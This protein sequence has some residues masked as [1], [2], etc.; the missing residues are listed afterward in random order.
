MSKDYPSDL[1][2]SNKALPS[3]SM[4]ALHVRAGLYRYLREFFWVRSVL[5]VETPMLSQAAVA[6]P[7]ILPINAQVMGIQH[8]LHTSPEYPM[9]RLLCAGSGS[10]FQIAKVFR[11]Q[12]AGKRH[13]PEF[14]ML[15]WYRVGFDHRQLMDEVAQLVME[16]LNLDQELRFTYQELFKTYAG[17]NPFQ[18]TDDDLKQVLKQRGIEHPEANTLGLL[19]LIMT[20]LI[21]PTLPQ[22]TL[23]F[24][25]D[26]PE[27][28][29]ALARVLPNDQGIA[30]AKRFELYVNGYELANGYWELKDAN[31]QRRRFE[32]DQRQRI[33]IGLSAKPIDEYLLQAMQQGMPDCAGVAMGLDRLLMLKLQTDSIASV[34]SFDVERA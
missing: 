26:F 24:V 34:I 10:I 9:K 22:D 5:E 1:A 16:Y 15:E 21:E 33:E 17:V 28:Q 19:D 14:S 2:F 11:D 3:A 7:Y 32:Q 4:E 27:T 6:D 29:A 23:V 31:E 13:N 12:E 18:V 30:F 8:Y 25:E 20:H